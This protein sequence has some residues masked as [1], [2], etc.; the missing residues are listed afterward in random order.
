MR[1]ES[2]KSL[3]LA[4]YGCGEKRPTCTSTETPQLIDTHQGK[5]QD[6]AGLLSGPTNK[7]AKH[8]G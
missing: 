3:V 8:E 1:D 5:A 4:A 6:G 2:Q 7:G